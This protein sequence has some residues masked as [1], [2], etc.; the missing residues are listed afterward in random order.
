MTKWFSHRCNKMLTPC[1]QL[2]CTVN[3]V[4]TT[5]LNFSDSNSG[6]RIKLKLRNR[7]AITKNSALGTSTIA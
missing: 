3:D 5:T 6:V 1:S 2:H 4:K 7:Y